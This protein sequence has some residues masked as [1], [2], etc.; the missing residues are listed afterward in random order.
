[1]NH[2]KIA[3]SV[4]N[5]LEDLSDDVVYWKELL[6]HNGSSVRMKDYVAKLYVVVFKFLAAIMTKW[7]KSSVAGLLRSF[8]SD[9]FKEEIQDKKTKIQDL[10]RRL[11]RQA[12]L[13]MQRSM[14]EAPSKAD[15]ARLI[16][17]SQANFQVERWKKM[18]NRRELWVRWS[19]TLL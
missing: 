18:A 7:S 2:D 8:D 16:A 17:D 1:M 11:Q 12:L 10:E 13:A 4:S 6:G 19:K 14:K 3:E 5:A 9:F 15:I